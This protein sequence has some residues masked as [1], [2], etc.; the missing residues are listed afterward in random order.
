MNSME[1][2]LQR[3]EANVASIIERERTLAKR[4]EIQNNAIEQ[5]YALCQEKG[6]DARALQ[7]L[8]ELMRFDIEQR[9]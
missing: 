9:K 4:N 6:F 3:L 2:R 8:D 7:I 1:Q 5:L